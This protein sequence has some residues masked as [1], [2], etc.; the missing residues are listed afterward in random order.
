MSQIGFV[1]QEQQTFRD[2]EKKETTV[3]WLECHFRVGGVRPFKAKM[4]PN[5]NKQN[6][7]EPDFYLYLRA[8]INKG[9]RFRD[10]RIGALWLKTK[11]FDGVEKTFMTGNVFMDF[12]EIPIAVW[13]AEPRFEG[14]VIEYLYDISMMKE[15]LQESQTGEAA[16]DAYPVE[17]DDSD[18][19]AVD[20]SEDI[21]F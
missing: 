18:I 1:K 13:R 21:P 5:K 11:A 2:K 4:S 14:E 10:M 8:N 16:D 20:P 19:P 15:K 7:N 9:D 12:K 6:E 3:K 17:Y